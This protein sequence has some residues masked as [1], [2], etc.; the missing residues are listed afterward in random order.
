MILAV[1][2]L[3]YGTSQF[4]R[5][6]YAGVQK[7]IANDLGLDRGALG[8]LGSAFFYSYALFQMPW[9]IASDRLGSRAVIGLGI[10]LTAVTMLGIRHGQTRRARSSS[11][12]SL[13]GI[14]AAAVYVPLTGGIA[15]W[16][17]EQE[18]GFSQGTLGGVGGALGEGAA[19]V[20]LPVLSIYFASG[21]RQGMQHA[22]GRDRRDRDLGVLSLLLGPHRSGLAAGD[23][24]KAVR[25]GAAPRR[26][27]LV[28]L[29]FLWSG[30]VVGIRDRTDHGSRCTPPMSNIGRTGHAAEPGRGLRGGS[31]ALLAFSLLGRAVGCPLAG[32]HVGRARQARHVAH[33]VLI[34]WLL[35]AIVSA[36]T[37]RTGVTSI[38][39][40]AVI[41]VL[42]GMS[43]N[44]FAHRSGR[45]L[46]RRTGRSGPR[47]CRVVRQHDR[48][49]S[50]ARPRWP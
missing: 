21:W 39:P 1:G 15:R 9:G 36:S 10:L 40:L 11:G 28:L 5:Q 48:A 35:L 29:R 33:A 20:L 26:A 6:N 23:D 38:G 31:C 45:D 22:C 27:R 49:S 30:F 43:V 44:L 24:A 42:L 18:R 16:F 17:P 2:I 32:K 4:S 8:L 34:G 41:A 19:Y 13:S 14:A 3:A 12:A 25:L 37:A 50:P 7:F 47:R 46:E